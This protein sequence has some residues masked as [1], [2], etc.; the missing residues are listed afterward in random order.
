MALA[1]GEALHAQPPQSSTLLLF[2][3]I[4][5]LSFRDELAEDLELLKERSVQV[6]FSKTLGRPQEEQP[7][8]AQ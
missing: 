1:S 5:S 7:E 4:L 8:E 2:A 6:D 3:S